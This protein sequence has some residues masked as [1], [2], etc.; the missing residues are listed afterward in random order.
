MLTHK[1][2]REE[3]SKLVSSVSKSDTLPP[4]L[5]KSAK[6]AIYLFAF[7]ESLI[8]ISIF[9]ELSSFGKLQGESAFSL[10]LN[11]FFWA[12][13]SVFSVSY[14]SALA[15]IP[16]KL[17]RESS[18]ISMLKNKLWAYVKTLVAIWSLVTVAFC[19]LAGGGAIV[20]FG[21][22]FISML[23]SVMIFNMDVSR[24]QLSGFFGALQVAKSEWRNMH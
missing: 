18:L 6:P 9:V 24:Y 16:Q 22:V 1:Q 15:M 19:L 21:T 14:C 20:I 23:L 3:I 2:V 11:L 8:L 12:I 17:R 10:L 7:S 4:S 13:C 5:F